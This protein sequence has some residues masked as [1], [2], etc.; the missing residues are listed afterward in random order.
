M[1]ERYCIKLAAA[2]AKRFHVQQ[3]SN[4]EPAEKKRTR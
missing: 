2:V 1:F 4:K 3:T